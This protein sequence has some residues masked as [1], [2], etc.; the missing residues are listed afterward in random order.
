MV[1]LYSPVSS[2]ILASDKA[3]CCGLNKRR[4]PKA[5]STAATPEFEK[6][7][8]AACAFNEGFGIY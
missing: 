4:I 7:I 8:M 5:L 1:L 6:G 3:G 2:A